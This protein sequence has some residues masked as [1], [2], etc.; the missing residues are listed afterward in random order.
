MSNVLI[1]LQNKMWQLAFGKSHLMLLLQLQ[2]ISLV[3][4]LVKVQISVGGRITFLISQSKAQ[5]NVL[6][7]CKIPDRVVSH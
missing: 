6:P 7:L 4:L 2:H 5:L 3:N 1:N